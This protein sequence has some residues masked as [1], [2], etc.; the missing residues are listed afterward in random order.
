LEVEQKTDKVADGVRTLIARI[1]SADVANV[2]NVIDDPAVVKQRAWLAANRPELA[3]QVDAAVALKMQPVDATAA[4]DDPFGLP[5]TDEGRPDEDMGEAHS[6]SPD[7]LIRHIDAK[8]TAMDVNSM[9]ASWSDAIAG[10]S[11]VDRERVANAQQGRIAE[12]KAAS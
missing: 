7:E 6:I 4:E 12:I 10:F 9:V 1:G 5:D 8:V 11:E 3:A 2:G